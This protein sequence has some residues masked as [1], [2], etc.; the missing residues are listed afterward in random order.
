MC[1][2]VSKS[3]SPTPNRMTAF[4]AAFSALALAAMASVTD[5]GSRPALRLSFVMDVS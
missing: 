5:S 3:G 4:P 1:S 2:G